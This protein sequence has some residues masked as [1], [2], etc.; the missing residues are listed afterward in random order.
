MADLCRAVIEETHKVICSL[1]ARHIDTVNRPRQATLL[2]VGCWDGTSTVRYA[3]AAGIPLANVRGI[4]VAADAIEKASR[5]FK[6]VAVNLETDVFPF[7]DA[8]FDVVVCNQVLEHLKNVYRP[9][10]EIWR[11]M[12]S[13][14]VLLLSVP[15]LAAL[16]NRILMALGLQPTSIRTFGP[17]VRGMTLRELVRFATFN[18]HLTLE[19]IRGVGFHPFPAHWPL[20]RVV[21]RAFPGL[22]HTAVLLLRKVPPGEYRLPHWEEWLAAQNLQTNY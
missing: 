15:N 8:H 9:L 21:A 4:E 16:H 12:K 7:P 11:V 22:A 17:H 6:C 14:G 1:L 2:D 13:G 3:R 10:T 18:G 19:K 20:T 5:L